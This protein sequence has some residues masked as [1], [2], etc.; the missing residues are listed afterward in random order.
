[1]RAGDDFNKEH[2]IETYKSLIQV[3]LQGLKLLA[4]VNGG[5]AVAL[6]AYLGNVAGKGAATPDMRVP[7]ISYLIGLTLCGLAFMTSYATQFIL[8]NENI[9][10]MPRGSH[11]RLVLLTALL[12]LLSLA[13]F[14]V[15]S[16]FAASVFRMS[17]PPSVGGV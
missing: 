3:A 7:M 12:A 11:K 16:L 5:A 17:Q 1:M 14:F 10:D 15:G 6:L 8:H 4:L 13:A 2:A 9:A